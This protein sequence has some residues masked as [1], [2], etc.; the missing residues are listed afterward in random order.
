M[1]SVGSDKYDFVEKQGADWL[2][3]NL[4]GTV[5]AWM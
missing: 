1:G 4:A 5:V 3:K 2:M